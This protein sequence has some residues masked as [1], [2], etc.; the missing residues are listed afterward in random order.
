MKRIFPINILESSIKWRGYSHYLTWL[1]NDITALQDYLYFYQRTFSVVNQDSVTRHEIL[2][3]TQNNKNLISS[4]YLFK[5]L[6]VYEGWPKPKLLWSTN[7]A[8]SNLFVNSQ[9]LSW[10]SMNSPRGIR[11]YYAVLPGQTISVIWWASSGRQHVAPWSFLDENENILSA[12]SYE[13]GKTETIVAPAGAKFLLLQKLPDGENSIEHSNTYNTNNILKN[14]KILFPFFLKWKEGVY[15][16]YY[17]T[18]VSFE[19]LDE[20]WD[21]YWDASANENKGAYKISEGDIKYLLDQEK[22]QI[23][24]SSFILFATKWPQKGTFLPPWPEDRRNSNSYISLAQNFMSLYEITGAAGKIIASYLTQGPG[25]TGTELTINLEFSPS[26]YFITN[27]EQKKWDVGGIVWSLYNYDVSSLTEVQISSSK[28][29]VW[30]DN[31]PILSELYFKENVT[32]QQERFICDRNWKTD[33]TNIE[34]KNVVVY[35]INSN[36]KDG[37]LTKKWDNV[38]VNL[39]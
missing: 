1:K 15:N 35:T 22:L 33:L 38:Y 12:A 6:V 30:N 2:R 7:V 10:E 29:I 25:T 8:D 14:R 24:P 32:H 37:S 26:R 4:N 39:I 28:G 16:P 34:N 20:Y 5:D 11:E 21:E 27:S 9:N 36:V 3:K 18:Y 23:L 13:S 31:F 17:E 19:N